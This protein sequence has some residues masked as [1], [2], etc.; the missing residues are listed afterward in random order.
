MSD[1]AQLTGASAPSTDD[2]L[3]GY[4][5][6]TWSIAEIGEAEQEFEQNHIRQVSIGAATASPGVQAQMAEMA[7]N[8][9]AWGYFVYGAPGFWARTAAAYELPFLLWLSLRAKQPQITRQAAATLVT[10]ANRRPLQEACRKCAGWKPPLPNGQTGGVS[11]TPA[12]PSEQ[13][14][15][16]GDGSTNSSADPAAA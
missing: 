16:P 12:P 8:A 3:P 15:S 4:I 11:Q 9:L 10:E 13:P 14:Q 1:L 5:L 6:S 2:V 7:Q